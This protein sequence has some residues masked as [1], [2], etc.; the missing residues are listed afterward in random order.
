VPDSAG[1]LNINFSGRASFDQPAV[2]AGGTF[3]VSYYSEF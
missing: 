1:K 2:K 3:K